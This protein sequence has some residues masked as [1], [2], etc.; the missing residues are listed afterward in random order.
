MWHNTGVWNVLKLKASPAGG[1]IITTT[2]RMYFSRYG[3]SGVLKG[4]VDAQ[5][6]GKGITPCLG[7]GGISRW[8]AV[9]RKKSSYRPHSRMTREVPITAERMFPRAD[10]ATRALR[11]LAALVEPKTAVKKSFAVISPEARMSSFGIA[12]KYAT[13]FL[14]C[15]LLDPFCK[16]ER[17]KPL[18]N[19]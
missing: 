5:N 1:A 13:V 10:T 11:A 8:L 19:M 15:Q 7:A 3:P 9:E 14:F 12:A 16:G 17:D 2:V 6:R 18:A 4:F